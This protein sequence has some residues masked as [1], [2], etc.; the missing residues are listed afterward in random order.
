[1]WYT[2]STKG[3]RTLL[4]SILLVTSRRFLLCRITL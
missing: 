4:L 1:M 3:R 2:K